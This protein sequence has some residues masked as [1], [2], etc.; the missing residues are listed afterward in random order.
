MTNAVSST[1]K[2]NPSRFLPNPLDSASNFKKVKINAPKATDA[3]SCTEK[4]TPASILMVNAMSPT[5]FAT[6]SKEVV[7]LSVINASANT[8]KVVKP[9]LL[10]PKVMV[11]ALVVVVALAPVVPKCAATFLKKVNV[12]KVTTA[13]SSTVSM[14]PASTTTSLLLPPQLENPGQ[15]ENP[16]NNVNPGSVNPG[17][18]ENVSISGTLVTANVVMI[19]VSLMVT[20]TTVM[21]NP[22]TTMMKNAKVLV[23]V[24][25]QV[26]TVKTLPK[27]PNLLMNKNATTTKLVA[28][29]LVIAVAADTLVKLKSSPCKKLTKFAT[30]SKQDAA[31]SVTSAVVSTLLPTKLIQYSS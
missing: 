3:A 25:V 8:L 28:A 21:L 4:M 11:L 7:A 2:V 30:T 20:T 6:T 12:P 23:V 1:V 16:G 31:A 13:A 22:I 24:V 15:P 9:N 17:L 29:A 19:A 18:V 27:A 5:K 10:P 14:T 26:L